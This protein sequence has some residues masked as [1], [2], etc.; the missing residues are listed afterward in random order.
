MQSV[1]EAELT[2]KGYLT[3]ELKKENPTIS[4]YR[5][6]TTHTFLYVADRQ[7][8]A[9]PLRRTSFSMLMQSELDKHAIEIPCLCNSDCISMC[10][11]YLIKK[12]RKG[13]GSYRRAQGLFGFQEE[14]FFGGKGQ[15][16]I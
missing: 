14:R 9:K 10:F 4:R 3:D 15:T 11:L 1:S 16:E 12:Y 7:G 5:K 13:G 6:L 8:F 2:G